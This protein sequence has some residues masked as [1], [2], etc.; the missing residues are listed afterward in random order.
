MWR[1]AADARARKGRVIRRAT[2]GGGLDDGGAVGRRTDAVFRRAAARSTAVCVYVC[3]C[4]CGESHWTGVALD[5]EHDHD[6]RDEGREEPEEDDRAGVVRDGDAAEREHDNAPD[7]HEREL[8]PAGLMARVRHTRVADERVREARVDGD[9]ER[10]HDADRG[11]RRLA[12]V[13]V[14]V[15]VDVQ[16]RE[17]HAGGEQLDHADAAAEVV[18][19]AVA[20]DGV[21][22]VVGVRLVAR[23]VH[24]RV[25]VVVAAVGVV[26]R[27]VAR[28]VAQR[29]E[30]VHEPH[31]RVRDHE[32]LSANEAPNN[33][34]SRTSRP[35]AR[36]GAVRGTR[37]DRTSDDRG[38]SQWRARVRRARSARG[39]RARSDDHDECHASVRFEFDGALDDR[40]RRRS[41]PDRSPSKPT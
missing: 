39:Q 12:L 22:V 28:D 1:P 14:R 41:D 23:A 33:K 25:E 30:P 5:E 8:A 40:R 2:S 26:V 13:A 3:R 32:H 10:R 29:E 20:E 27:L 7:Q 34:T 38:P 24:R 37:T 18:A 17:D 36:G 4:E 16:R 9:R 11:E 21:R 6:E 19:L 35:S 15:G 31:Q